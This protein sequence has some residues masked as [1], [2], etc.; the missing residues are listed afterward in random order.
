MITQQVVIKL[1]LLICPQT[2]TESS[3][4]GIFK[5][6]RISYEMTQ[7]GAELCQSHHQ[8][9]ASNDNDNVVAYYIQDQ[10]TICL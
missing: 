6:V 1:L 7:A 4:I 10:A 8:L 2:V 5:E 9:A 3:L